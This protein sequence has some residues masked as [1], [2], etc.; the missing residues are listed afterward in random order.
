MGREGAEH[1]DENHRR[2]VSKQRVRRIVQR[3]NELNRE[4]ACRRGG[5]HRE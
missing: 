3:T 5:R 4:S 1:G 2:E